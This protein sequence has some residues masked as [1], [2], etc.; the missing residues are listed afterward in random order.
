MFLG[1]SEVWCKS[2]TAL[3]RLW[4]PCRICGNIPSALAGI[5][6]PERSGGKIHFHG[7]ILPPSTCAQLGRQ[8][9]PS[10]AVWCC[11]A[12]FSSG[13]ESRG[14]A[15][16]WGGD[17]AALS[18]SQIY[19]VNPNFRDVETPHLFCVDLSAGGGGNNLKGGEYSCPAPD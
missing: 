19:S 11:C 10:V 8:F 12:K 17:G 7:Q 3:E 13:D 1:M 15:G 2:H 6:I 18:A 9:L 16:L 14:A 4:C 5:G